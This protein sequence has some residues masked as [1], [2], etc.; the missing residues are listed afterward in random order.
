MTLP[1]VACETTGA[2]AYDP[3]VNILFT[4]TIS[5]VEAPTEGEVAAATILH[6]SSFKLT[7]IIGWEVET[8]IIVAPPWG[9]FSAQRPGVQSVSRA[10]LVFAADRAGDD[11][12]TLLSRGVTGHVLILPSGPFLLHPDAPI[13]VYPVTVS[14]VTQMQ[15]LRNGGSLL[16]V[17]FAVRAPVGENVVVVA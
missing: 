11:I 5:D 4:S 12:R 14:Q 8:G 13:N 17:S 6:P 1:L 7:D 16:L 15:R 9:R 2:Y 10:E 3:H